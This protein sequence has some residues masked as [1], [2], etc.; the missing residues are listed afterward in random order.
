[1]SSATAD[2]RPSSS[3]Q[4]HDIVGDLIDELEATLVRPICGA[5]E[6]SYGHARRLLAQSGLCR[7]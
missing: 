7:P 3:K 2:S 4:R 5:S 6:T 1:M